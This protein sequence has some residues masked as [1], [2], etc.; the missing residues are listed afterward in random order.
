MILNA[1]P[2]GCSEWGGVRVE[3]GANRNTAEAV[4]SI[5]KLCDS[6]PQSGR[7]K[8]YS[9]S[10]EV[11]STDRHREYIMSKPNIIQKGRRKTR[12]KER[13]MKISLEEEDGR[14][15]GG[16]RHRK[17]EMRARSV[18]TPT[19]NLSGAAVEEK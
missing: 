8:Y 13:R 18:I 14:R 15:I 4:P 12:G 7:S 19:C 9:P 16:W 2:M 3:C 10:I 17:K 11:A 6:A 5:G 1:C